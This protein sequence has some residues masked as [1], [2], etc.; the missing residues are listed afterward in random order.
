MPRRRDIIKTSRDA[1]G[2]IIM[3]KIKGENER[4]LWEILNEAY[5]GQ[6]KKDERG[7]PGRRFRFDCRTIDNSPIGKVAI[8]IDGGI[9][10]FYAKRKDGSRF[11]TFKGGHNSI[12]GV[13]RDHIKN[14]LAVLDGWKV[15]KYTPD[16]LK[17]KPWQIIKDVRTLCG[18]DQKGQTFLCFDECSTGAM[19][20]QRTLA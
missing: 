5:P 14:N 7:I 17:T 2:G 3:E 15:L 16:I 19:Q 8:E 11:L 6:W 20:I 1:D 9:Y 10:P 13:K 12:D 18:Y 4:L